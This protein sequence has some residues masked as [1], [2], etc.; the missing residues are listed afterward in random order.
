MRFVYALMCLIPRLQDTLEELE[1][2]CKSTKIYKLCNHALLAT[3]DKHI[4]IN[5]IDVPNER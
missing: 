1:F 4:L 2:I 3:D 5:Q